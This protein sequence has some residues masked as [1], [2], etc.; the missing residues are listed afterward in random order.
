MSIL[1]ANNL[2]SDAES[3]KNIHA[4]ALAKFIAIFLN[5]YC[6]CARLVGMVRRTRRTVGN[7]SDEDVPVDDYCDDSSFSELNSSSDSDED[8]ISRCNYY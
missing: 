4:D 5:R 3:F 6:V 2:H 1:R 8:P 7:E